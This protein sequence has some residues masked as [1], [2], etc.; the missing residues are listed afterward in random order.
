MSRPPS[1]EIKLPEKAGGYVRK[2]MRKLE[3]DDDGIES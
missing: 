1:Q 2:L 3:L